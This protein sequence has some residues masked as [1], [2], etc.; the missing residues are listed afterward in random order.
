MSDFEDNPYPAELARSLY[1]FALDRQFTDFTIT[2]K[3]TTIHCHQVVI[4][5]H[6]EFFRIICLSGN[7]EASLE[8]SVLRDDG[9]VLA[10][11]IEF[12]YLGVTQIT[13][14]NVE[15]LLLAANFIK[16]EQLKRKCE[17]F[18]IANLSV[19]NLLT[20]Q[21]LAKKVRLSNLRGACMQLTREKFR[22]VSKTEWLPTL[23]VDEVIAYL[24]DN[25]LK[26]ESEDHV[27]DALNLWLQNSVEP[28]AVMEDSMDELLSCVRLRFCS[29]A[30]LEAIAKDTTVMEKFRF[31]I[32]EYLLH[33]WHGEGKPRKSYRDTRP[34]APAGD[35][36]KAFS[37]RRSKEQEGSARMTYKDLPSK[38]RE[39]EKMHKETV[40]IVG[41]RKSDNANH[42]NIISIDS[43]PTDSVITQSSIC[44]ESYMFGYSVCSE[45]DSLIVS[46]GKSQV[47]A[48]SSSKVHK[49]C[50]TTGKWINLPKIPKGRDYH[51]SALLNRKLYIIGGRYTLNHSSKC[52]YNIS[53]LDLDSL[54]WSE[55]KAMPEALSSVGIAVVS[56]QIL[57]IGGST[58]YH[59]VSTRT[60]KYNPVTNTWTKCQ[61]VPKQGCCYHR[62]TVTGNK[63]FVGQHDMSFFLQYNVP[64]D[65]WTELKLPPKQV[66]Q[67]ALVSKQDYV[68]ALG[69]SIDGKKTDCV[70]RYDPS[71][72]TWILEKQTLPLSL[73]LHWAVV[74]SMPKCM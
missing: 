10:G 4:S 55:G 37:E 40:A 63:V 13:V 50:T 67:C 22:E 7:K 24:K 33:G 41:G 46:G 61:P 2:A 17:H 66:S 44:E 1:Q 8:H 34:K 21:N 65:Q 60:D 23:S 64:F 9:H 70:Q 49:F 30:K 53:I 38:E 11:V 72:K 39:T 26:A 36:P 43:Q 14:R 74:L 68:L 48:Y 57:V 47:K 16:F 73:Y 62:T 20:Y 69:G 12:M 32:M 31:K 6:S 58:D 5:A 51:G 71:S 19:D 45:A 59:S 25:E 54:T 29:K 42:A 28:K 35:A 27:V 15:A 3:N 18:I 52:V 56:D